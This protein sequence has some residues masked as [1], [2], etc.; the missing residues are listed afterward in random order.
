MDILAG[1]IISFWMIYFYGKFVIT[2]QN[3]YSGKSIFLFSFF[4]F[5]LCF[6]FFSFLPLMCDGVGKKCL[7]NFL[8]KEDMSSKIGLKKKDLNFFFPSWKTSHPV[9]IWMCA[10]QLTI[11]CIRFVSEK[12]NDWLWLSAICCLNLFFRFSP[13]N[14]CHF[15]IKVAPVLKHYIVQ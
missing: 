1:K 9:Y 13:F 14:S 7:I 8:F 5:L 2:R 4:F 10:G 6:L 3:G 11:S 12:R 15:L